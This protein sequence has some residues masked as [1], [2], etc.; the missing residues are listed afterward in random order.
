[1]KKEKEEEEEERDIRR[2]DKRS[3]CLYGEYLFIFLVNKIIQRRKKFFLLEKYNL[4]DNHT[5]SQ[6]EGI[7]GKR[8]RAGI[9]QGGISQKNMWMK[10]EERRQGRGTIRRN[11]EG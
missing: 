3:I 10:E 7:D 9:I 5:L 8:N 2:Q 11:S 1:M 6:S 4:N